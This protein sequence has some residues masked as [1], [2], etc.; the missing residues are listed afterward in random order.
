MGRA[1]DVR[2]YV[3]QGTEV[4]QIEIELKGRGRKAN[5]V[6]WRRFGRD[7]DKSEWMLNGKASTRKAI[8]NLI[9]SFG[10][11]ADNLW[12]AWKTMLLLTH[13]SFLPQDKVADFAKMN[14]VTV[15][16]ETMRAAGD[17]NL[18]QWH[19]DLVAN[20]K[21]AREVE[22]VGFVPLLWLTFSPSR[23]RHRSVT[24][25]AGRWTSWNPMFATTSA[26]RT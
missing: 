14:P 25:S 7:S 20:G 26:N 3:K 21:A 9:Q 23:R 4:A 1:H 8:Q 15:L 19:E 16:K 24:I 2:S 12:Y 17:P 22:T 11:Q 13:S 6:I 5:P 10:V 18:S